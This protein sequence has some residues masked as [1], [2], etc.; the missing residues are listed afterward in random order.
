MAKKRYYQGPKDRKDESKGM[1]NYYDHSNGSS[2]MKHRSK[3]ED[4]MMIR[5]DYNAPANLPQEV[6]HKNYPKGSYGLRGGLDDTIRGVDNQL[7]E[8]ERQMDRDRG[9]TKY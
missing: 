3:Y 5:E 2:M 6:V 4:S 1:K 9:D 7:Y 8:D